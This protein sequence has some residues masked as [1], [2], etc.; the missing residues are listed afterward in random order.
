MLIITGIAQNVQASF[1][2]NA[3]VFS[4]IA[5]LFPVALIIVE[6]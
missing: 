1:C 6:K 2:F 3:E 5:L 4:N